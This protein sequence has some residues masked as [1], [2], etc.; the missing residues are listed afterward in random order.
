MFNVLP[1][2]ILLSN[3]LGFMFI[4]FSAFNS[5]LWF[6]QWSQSF[7]S[8]FYSIQNF[9][10][11]QWQVFLLSSNKKSR[12]QLSRAL[13]NDLESQEMTHR[14]KRDQPT[15]LHLRFPWTDSSR[16]EWHTRRRR[17]RTNSFGLSFFTCKMRGL[18]II[19]LKTT[20]IWSYRYILCINSPQ[21]YARYQKNWQFFPLHNSFG[22]IFLIGLRKRGA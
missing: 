19:I 12:V 5:F 2:N 10:F 4:S 1:K 11:P 15:H 7:P 21:F 17:A 6:I 22:Q 3:D 8:F 16:R 18:D 14:E 20:D 9:S 13:D